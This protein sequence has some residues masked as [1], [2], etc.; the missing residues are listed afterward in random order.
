MGKLA[1]H[2]RRDPAELG[3]AEVRAFLVHLYREKPYKPTTHHVVLCVLRCFYRVHLG[4]EDWRLLKVARAQIGRS[5]PRGLTRPQVARLWA[6]VTEPRFRTLLRLIYVCGLRIGE[7]FALEV[8]DIER[9]GPCVRMKRGKGGHARVVP[10]PRAMLAELRAWWRT[11]RNPRWLFPAVRGDRGGLAMAAGTV[12]TRLRRARMAASLPAHTTPHALRHS[13][14]T[15]MLE[16]GVCI[17][18]ISACLGHTLLQ[19]TLL[20]ARVTAASEERAREA[21]ARLVAEK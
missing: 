7:A 21:A 3:E 10:L 8:T 11:H 20:Y 6:E 9:D 19:T 4:R 14:A 16:E 1:E 2:A 13:Y 12:Q 17:R 15:H 5:L 18:V